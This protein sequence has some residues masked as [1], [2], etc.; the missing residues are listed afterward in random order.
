MNY[1]NNPSGNT[2]EKASNLRA[3]FEILAYLQVDAKR[4]GYGELADRLEFAMNHAER[5]LSHLKNPQ[6]VAP[7]STI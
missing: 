1:S 7:M 5:Q 4:D 6:T 2:D 3:I